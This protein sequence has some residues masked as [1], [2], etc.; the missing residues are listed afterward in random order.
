MSV[1]QKKQ[2][3]KKINYLS[4]LEAA[5]RLG[6]FKEAEDEMNQTDH[7]QDK[8]G[9]KRD[10]HQDEMHR[11]PTAEIPYAIF[12]F[13]YADG[14]PEGALQHFHK[15]KGVGVCVFFHDRATWKV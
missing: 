14:S 6:S 10:A 9:R 4:E 15:G 11:I 13:L 2:K 3:M 7:G 12:M 5:E 8:Q 1:E